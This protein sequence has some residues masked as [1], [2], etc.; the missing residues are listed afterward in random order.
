[1]PSN[2]KN[3]NRTHLR[4]EYKKVRWWLNDDTVDEENFEKLKEDEPEREVKV[5]RYFQVS[6]VK[7]K[8]IEVTGISN[9]GYI[10]TNYKG[11][12]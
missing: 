10:P 3:E 4:L 11:F 12:Y 2:N 6:K 1:M 7:I 8:E 5:K 9:S